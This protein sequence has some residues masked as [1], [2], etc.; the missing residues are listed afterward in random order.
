MVE[1][2]DFLPLNFQL[3]NRPCLI[4]GGG[5]VALRKAAL[6]HRANAVI[7]VVALSIDENVKELV[8]NSGGQFRM[9][10]FNESDLEGKFIVIAATNDDVLN[11]EVSVAAQQRK[12][13]VN[14]VD[15]PSLCSFIFPAIIDR[16]PVI[17]AVSSSGQ[18]PVLTRSL[19]ATIESVVPSAYGQLASL[20][21]EF[22]DKV[23]SHF[24]DISDRRHFWE[25]ILQGPIAEMVFA[26]KITVAKAMLQKQLVNTTQSS[27]QTGEVYLVGAGPGDPDL[28]TFKALRLMQK[29]DVVL[30]DRLVSEQIVDLTRRDA[31]KIYVGKAPKMHT[32]SQQEINELLVKLAKEGKKV[33]RLKGGDPFVF[34]RGGE[35]IEH[36]AA[37]DISFQV[38]PGIT[39]A[40]GCACYSGIPLT[41][42]DY[43]QSVRFVTGHLI[44]NSIELPWNELTQS[45]Q[46]V[47]F[48]MGLL[49]LP[50][51]CQK[52][53]EFGMD[54]TTPIALIQQGTTPHQR[55]YSS[56]LE[57]MPAIVVQQQVKPPALLI[58][59]E[60]V[61][62]REKLAWFEPF[63]S[64]N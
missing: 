44:N 50:I 32:V 34:G 33:V 12:L 7:Y 51:I 63:M 46:T 25:R 1:Y 54:K 26:G 59:G 10:S 21:G 8:K 56:T 31:E 38:I 45:K 22:R 60:V 2:V 35:E 4:V 64:E 5:S 3:T 37:Q 19:R 9:G 57:L 14:V 48:Y 23:K 41:H 49:G 16:S 28:L 52:L 15:K 36:L 29:A 61:K 6:L 27:N 24:S 30:Y 62:L 18:S 55:V 42:R 43:A 47:V 53:L 20:V 40:S 11:E 58:V 17:I 13:P 39:S